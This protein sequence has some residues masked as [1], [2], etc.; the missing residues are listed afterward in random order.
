MAGRRSGTRATGPD[1]A[2]ASTAFQICCATRLRGQPGSPPACIHR[3]A[4]L[5]LQCFPAAPVRGLPPPHLDNFSFSGW[6]Q[7]GP[8]T[9]H[10][11]AQPPL[12]VRQVGGA[13]AGGD[14]LG[15]LREVGQGAGRKEWAVSRGQDWSRQAR[16]TG[17]E[18]DKGGDA[19]RQAGR[20]AGGI[21]WR[22]CRHSHGAASR[23]LKP[24]LKPQPTS[25]A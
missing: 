24:R 21:L 15:G 11:L 23:R 19:G 5:P 12:R 2:A 13:V 1:E 16:S 14:K 3:T 7:V 4:V 22:E 8:H 6:V 17:R 20:Q 9:L 10:L 25:A 18:V